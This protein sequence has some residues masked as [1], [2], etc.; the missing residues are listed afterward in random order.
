MSSF[1]SHDRGFH[2]ESVYML[3]IPVLFYFNRYFSDRQVKYI[4]YCGFFLAIIVFLQ[5]RTVWI[6]TSVALAVNLLLIKKANLKI[7]LS[8]FIPI[9]LIL[10]VIIFFAGFFIATNEEIVSKLNENI[11][12][13]ANPTGGAF[14]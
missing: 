8:A 5:H 7:D 4:L 1:T 3:I 2:A 10:F 6:C 12:D 11:D 13:I 9:S 14:V